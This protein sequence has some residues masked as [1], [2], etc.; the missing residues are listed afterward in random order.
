MKPVTENRLRWMAGICGNSKAPLR[1]CE[2]RC[3]GT[4]HGQPHDEQWI[5]DTLLRSRLAQLG[6]EIDPRQ[7]DWIGYGEFASLL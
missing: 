4:L 1:Q 7:A 5:E 3:G 2:C 6:A